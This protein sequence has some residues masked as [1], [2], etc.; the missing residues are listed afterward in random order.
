MM[1]NQTIPFNGEVISCDG[2]KLNPADPNTKILIASRHMRN[3][4]KCIQLEYR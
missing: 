2:I 4:S 3:D 1:E